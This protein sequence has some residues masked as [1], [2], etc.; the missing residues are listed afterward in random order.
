MSTLDERIASIYDGDYV[1]IWVPTALRLRMVA[2][3]GRMNAEMIA[4]DLFSA[5]DFVHVL[6]SCATEAIE[7]REAEAGLRFCEWTGRKLSEQPKEKRCPAKGR[8]WRR[9][10][11]APRR[12][13]T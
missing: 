5:E 6:I 3:V 10:L 13:T 1:P 11:G 8:R 12:G 7:I 2:E 9:L 4:N